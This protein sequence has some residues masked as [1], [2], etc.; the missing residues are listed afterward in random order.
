[1]ARTSLFSTIIP[2]LKTSPEKLAVA[3]KHGLAPVYLLSG[4]EPLTQG[5]AADA[6]RA[7]ARGAGF[8]E[9]EVFFIDRANSGPW[10][11]I[12]AASQALSLFAARRI[13]EVRIPGGKPGTEGAKALQELATLANPDLIL[14]VTTGELDWSTQ[15]SGWVAA[16]DH[17]GVWI[18]C[19]AVG[20]ARFASW[21]AARA[22]AEGLTLDGAAA[23][24]LAAQTEGNL[25]A[26]VQELRKLALAGY[27]QVGAA[28]V[29][30]AS[31]QS[32][33]FDVTQLGA[34][35]LQGDCTRALHVLSGLKAEGVEPTLVLW[36]LWQELRMVWMTLVPGAPVPAVWSRNRQLMAPAA[37]RMKSLGRAHFA[38]LNERM[39]RTDRVLKGRAAGHAWD[40]LALLVAEFARGLPVLT[41]VA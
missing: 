24:A 19:V 36:T 4:E 34:A 29:L 9:R 16:L 20:T 26:A 27:S 28:E 41:R 21:L 31:L 37:A 17:A 6:I 40:E 13:I 25:L 35:V 8:T 7:A 23:E 30:A 5:E 12:F 2:V 11:E 32:S 3:L 10:E 1:M 33:R 39:A 18:D 14:M 22:R 15:K 38:G